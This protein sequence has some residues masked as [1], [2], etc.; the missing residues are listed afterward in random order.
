MSLKELKDLLK[1]LRAQGVLTYNTTELSL[2]LSE[3]LP[4]KEQA[5]APIQ[6]E[7]ELTPDEL[8]YYSAGL[9]VPQHNEEN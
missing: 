4:A 3:T 8:R 7:R 2:T 9:D 6:E 5:S 1:V